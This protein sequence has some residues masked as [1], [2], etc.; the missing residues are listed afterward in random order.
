V[1]TLEGGTSEVDL[2]ACEADGVVRGE[3]GTMRRTTPCL[4][5]PGSVSGSDAMAGWL[6]CASCG[7]RQAPGKEW[8]GFCGSR[9]VTAG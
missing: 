6:E 2:A 4:C 8:C 5:L 9:W 3:D 1:V 7:T